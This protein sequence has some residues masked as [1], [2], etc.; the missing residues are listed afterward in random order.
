[1]GIFYNL[2]KIFKLMQFILI[3]VG[4]SKTIK[5]ATESFLSKFERIRRVLEHICVRSIRDFDEF[6]VD[7]YCEP[8]SQFMIL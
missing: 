8:L 2:S 1:M 7:P 6:L 3:V 4:T 5:D